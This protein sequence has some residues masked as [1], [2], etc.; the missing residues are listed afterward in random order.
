MC[1][2]GILTSI[3]SRGF[4]RAVTLSSTSPSPRALQRQTKHQGSRLQGESC[5]STEFRRQSAW[6][7]APA[8]EPGALGE[9]K[10][11]TD[12]G[13]AVSKQERALAS[14]HVVGFGWLLESPIWLQAK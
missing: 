10:T 13:P 12:I 9:H 5:S 11:P 2:A 1:S 7:W 3:K 4:R 14:G 8:Y 6:M